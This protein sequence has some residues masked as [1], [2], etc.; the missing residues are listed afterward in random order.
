MAMINKELFNDKWCYPQTEP[1]NQGNTRKLGI[2]PNFFK[3]SPDCEG[4]K[5]SY[6]FGKGEG[7]YYNLGPT[8]C[9]VLVDALQDMLK[10]SEKDVLSLPF[11]GGNKGTITLSVGRGDDLIP[12][13]AIGG[14]ING[15]RRTKK[16][17][18]TTPKGY[19]I[20]RNG[21]PV[22]DLENAERMCRAFIGRFHKFQEWLDDSYKKREWNQNGGGRQGSGGYNRQG[23]G[24]NNNYQGGGNQ[25]SA[26]AATDNFDDYV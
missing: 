26:P 15:Q 21:T 20:V 1:D 6:S 4:L 24:N 23:G 16:F 7:V 9:Q 11:S 13:M 14:E 5:F 10:K 3:D 2:E 17:F 25:Q 18:F 19:G 12:F 8:M 22:S